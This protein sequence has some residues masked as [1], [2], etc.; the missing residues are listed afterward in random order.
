MPTI[1]LSTLPSEARYDLAV[2][3]AGAPGLAC[4]TTAA[5]LGCRVLLVE[6]TS[7][8]GGTSAYSAGTLWVPNTRHSQ[9][10][11]AEDDFQKASGY[12]DRAVGNHSPKAMRD[13]FL[14]AGPEAIAFL[15]DRAGIRLR[16]RPFHPDYLSEIEGATTG[17]RAL[18]PTPFDGRLLGKD[19]DL[20]RPPIPEFTIFGGLMVDKDDIASLLT[21][22]RSAKSFLRSLRLVGRYAADRMRYRRGTRLVMGNA[23]VGHLLLAAKNAGVDIMVDARVDQLIEMN[24]RVDGIVVEQGGATRRI[25]LSRGVVLA[26]GGFAGNTEMRKQKLPAGLPEFGPGAPGPKGELHEMAMKLGGHYGTEAWQPCFWAPCSINRRPD[27]SL[28][29]FPHF[30]FDRSKPGTVCVGRNGRRFVNESIS[31]HLFGAAMIEHNKNGATIPAYIIAD[32]VAVQKYGLGMVRPGARGLKEYLASGYVTMGTTPRELADRLGLDAANVEQTIARMNEYA[33]SGMDP[34]F[35][36]GS[37]VYQRANG[38]ASH[39]PNPTLGKIATPPYYA[40]KLFPCPIGSAE[41]F[42]T[43]ENARIL[44]ADG[45]AIEN[46]YAIGNDMQSVMGGVYPGPGITLGPGIVF[47]YIAASHAAGRE[48]RTAAW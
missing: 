26:T 29:V 7:H 40:V 4:A 30:V 38:D 21:M 34:E 35:D 18:E 46:L 43:D 27:G 10:L 39:G 1:S 48:D 42:V 2:L 13:R 32:S 19:L 9:A 24:G 8:V 37:T 20:V 11:G 17:G 6:R 12:L 22:T 23:L 36:R 41:G 5:L 31:Y 33:E 16:P 47:G 28:A 44:R 3:G 45:S 25:L 15:E 14:S